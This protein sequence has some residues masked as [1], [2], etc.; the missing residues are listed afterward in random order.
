MCE[1][2]FVNIINSVET[3]FTK[4]TLIRSCLVCVNL[5]QFKS[6][7]VAKD[8]PKKDVPRSQSD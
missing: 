6:E 5:C 2:V 1:F 7:D 3:F 8:V 4:I